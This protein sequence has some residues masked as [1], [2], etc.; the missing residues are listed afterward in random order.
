MYHGGS[1]HVLLVVPLVGG[2]EF[3]LPGVLEVSVVEDPVDELEV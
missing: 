3:G 1:V 2:G